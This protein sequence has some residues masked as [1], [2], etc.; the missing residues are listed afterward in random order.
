MN[1]LN[2]NKLQF[3]FVSE[4]H[5]WEIVSNGALKARPRVLLSIMIKWLS[6]SRLKTS[7]ESEPPSSYTND[8]LAAITGVGVPAGKCHIY[9]VSR[10]V[11]DLYK[12]KPGIRNR[13][14]FSR[15]FLISKISLYW[16]LVKF[17]ILIELQIFEL[18][19]LD[20]NEILFNLK[21]LLVMLLIQ[22]RLSFGSIIGLN[23]HLWRKTHRH[24]MINAYKNR[25][26]WRKINKIK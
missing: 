23:E 5:Q 8:P 22:N 1:D 9:S 13:N 14:L 25:G 12:L 18:W 17:L 15:C 19:L 26:N 16:F 4:I 6:G 20:E 11:T 10:Y 24:Y 2:Y 3:F 7:T 21:E